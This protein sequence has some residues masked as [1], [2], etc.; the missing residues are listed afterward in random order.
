MSLLCP[1]TAFGLRTNT[2]LSAFLLAVGVGAIAQVVI[3]IVPS[4]RDKDGRLLEPATVGGV[5]VG[6][7]TMFLTGSLVTA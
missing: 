1:L 5:A 3:Q 4:L 6:L 2:E 7:P